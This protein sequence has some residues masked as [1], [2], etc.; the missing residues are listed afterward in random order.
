M[1]WIDTL[2]D[3]LIVASAATAGLLGVVMFLAQR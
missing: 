1:N 3:R 2:L